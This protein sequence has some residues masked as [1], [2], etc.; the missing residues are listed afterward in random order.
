LTGILT[1]EIRGE[2]D[3]V[4]ARQRARQVA[5][6]LGF[7]VQ[8]QTR[9]S[10]A[11]SE[12]A[13]NAFQ[14]AGGGSAEFGFEGGPPR[15]L[16]VLVRDRG[17]GIGDVD[18]V[19]DGRYA[20]TTGL[21]LGL[22]GV[23]RVM[24][25]F[26]VQSSAGSGTVV[27]VGKVLPDRAA[28]VAG[29]DLARIAGELAALT[30]ASPYEE[31]QRQNR[32]LLQALDALRTR[33][34]KTAR[35]NLELAE[36]N[37]A[38]RRHQDE[39]A[40][41]NRELEATNRGV[42][43]LYAEV[44]ERAFSLQRVSELKSRFLSNMSHEFRTPLNSIRSLAQFLLEPEDGPLSAEKERQARYILKAAE[45]LSDLVNDLLDLAKV[46]AGKV[47]VRPESFDVADLFGALRGMFRPL[48][49]P[50][51]PVALTFDAA[52]GLPTLWTDEGKVAQ[53]LR[54]LISNALKFT[55][56]GSVRVGAAAGPGDVAVFTVADTG[57][58]IAAEHRGRVF[59]E[60]GQVDGP[61][62]DRV[63]G[64][65]LGLPLSRKL[66]EILG[67]TLTMVSA[68]GQGTTFT[69]VIPRVYADPEAAL[70][71]D[72]A[73]EAVTAAPPG[74]P[75]LVVEDDPVSLLGYRR[76]LQGTAFRVVPARSID[77]ARRGLVADRPAAVLLDVRLEAESGWSLL[78]EMKRREETRAI[79]VFVLTVVEGRERA[80]SLGAE[81][82]CL[83]PVEKSWLLG[84]LNAL[85]AHGPPHT[86][87]VVDDDEVGRYLL[88]SLLALDGRYAVIEAATGA[89]AVRRAVE[90]RPGAIFLDLMMPDMS[91][92]EVLDRLKS[93]P[94]TRE[95]PVIINSS[96]AIDEADRLRLRGSAAILSSKQ[97][98]SRGELLRT[99]RD[100]LAGAR[101]G[102][103]AGAAGGP[104]DG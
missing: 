16:R 53:V 21:G 87:L 63:T 28:A 58:G 80:L 20:S 7:D 50:A 46:E 26:D 44:D 5:G 103:G 57:I 99:L 73:E 52:G 37:I 65:G 92:F 45:G 22:A 68:V 1:V 100:A 10:T 81:D 9:V 12:L 39:L 17:P 71:G 40:H 3:V 101:P 41:L 76:H 62:Q 59:E 104:A 55:E 83:K 49:D 38:L 32:E 2:Q 27:T 34:S 85:A 75:V 90:D 102:A 14:Y 11:V 74:V 70:A 72:L 77:E 4:L 79:P 67:G 66:A 18:A 19:L 36:S 56:R 33:E 54:N 15:T 88:G 35:L 31:I 86:I 25:Q 78:A 13:R 43:A 89:E 98:T 51:S 97:G 48:H 47:V 82:F 29:P 42:V 93:D 64:T 95:V 69:A 96:K 84:K 94:V 24:D 30:A 6:L 23:R 8:D 60:F 61:L 91:G